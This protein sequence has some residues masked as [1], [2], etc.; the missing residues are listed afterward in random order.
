MATFSRP[1]G[2]LAAS[3]VITYWEA[4]TAAGSAQRTPFTGSFES[5]VDALDTLLRDAVALR[6]VAD[7]PLGAFLSGGVDSSLIVSLMQAQSSRPVRTYTIGFSE[8]EYDES[9][10]AKAVAA[11]LGTDHTEM[12]VRPTDA[13]ALIPELPRMFDEPFADSSQLPTALVCAMARK[14][15]TVVLSGDGGDEGFCGYGRYRVWQKVWQSYGKFPGPLRRLLAAIIPRMPTGLIDATVRTLSPLLPSFIPRRSAGERLQALAKL[16]AN[17]SPSRIYKRLVSHWAEP[18]KIVLRGRELKPHPLFGVESD[19]ESGFIQHLSVLDASTYL[20]DDI[21]VKMDRASMAV[22]L[23][24]RAP[25]L[26]H[27]ILEFAWSLPLEFKFE[28]QCS[29]RI[30]WEL[31]GRYVPRELVDRPKTGFG[32]PIDHWLRGPLR[33]WAESLL[34][35]DRLKREGYF[36][37]TPIRR[38]WDEHAS[39]T[40]DWHYHLW[41]VLMF[42]AWLDN[43][44]VPQT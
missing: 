4:A 15:V 29:K 27:R 16:A 19:D 36:D 31:L 10:H 9:H 13:L 21:L 6:M 34:S 1:R 32:V 12:H 14:H 24:A 20:P 23:E 2:N 44:R 42:Q 28:R 35:L 8:S 26:D 40:R 38:A 11:H 25:L 33:D 43:E 39:G 3:P 7:V 41:D 37:P 22:G 18:E 17:P 30:L 5:A